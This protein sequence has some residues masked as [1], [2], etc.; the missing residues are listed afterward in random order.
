M[1]LLRVIFIFQLVLMLP[2]FAYLLLT[3]AHLGTL[4]LLFYLVPI[5]LLASL[6]ALWQFIRQPNRRRLAAAIFATPF[7]C[8]AA[9]L[10]ITSLSGG[11]VAPA[12]LIVAVVALI[13][14]AA[15]VLLSNT[16]QWREAGLFANRRFNMAIVI[17]L[18]VFFL[19]LWFPI[20]AWLS[21]DTA[22]SLPSNMVDRNQVVKAGALYLI[23]LA[24]PGFCL[25]VFSLLYAPVGLVRN[26][27]GRVAHFGQLV[28]AL[29][30]LAS[31]L[32]VALAVFVGMINPG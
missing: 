23:A 22:Y 11:P 15:L 30:L 32:A 19:L 8:L 27:G 21:S 16:G 10:G 17:A 5:G 7:L 3:P 29:I 2:A 13:I 12:V 25:S 20:I 6:V 28:M 4:A 31:L 26:P 24:V 9:P 18:S 1:I 14:V